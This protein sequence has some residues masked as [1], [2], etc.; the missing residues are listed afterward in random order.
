MLNKSCYSRL[1]GNKKQQKNKF[2][3][4]FLSTDFQ[5]RVLS[6]KNKQ[7]VV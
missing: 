6:I 4:P 1:D 7:K 2:K 5:N 3:T